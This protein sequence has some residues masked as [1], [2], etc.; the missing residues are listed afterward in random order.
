MAGK[1]GK[2]KKKNLVK[3]VSASGYVYYTYKSRKAEG[4]LTLKKY[5]PNV[6]QHV[7]FVEKK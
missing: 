7:E 4:K 3:L 5:D 1:K 2:K 6:R